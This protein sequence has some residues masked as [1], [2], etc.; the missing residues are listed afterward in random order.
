MDYRLPNITAFPSLLE[1]INKK[2]FDDLQNHD[3]NNDFVPK[4]PLT[5]WDLRFQ[6]NA[7]LDTYGFLFKIQ[8]FLSAD[9]KFITLSCEKHEHAAAIL[10]IENHYLLDHLR[11]CFDLSGVKIKIQLNP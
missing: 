2:A 11:T 6:V 1:L 4:I 3:F 7:F 5:E 9:Q 8:S 10:N